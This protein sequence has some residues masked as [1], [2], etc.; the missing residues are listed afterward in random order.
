MTAADVVRAIRAR[1]LLFT[2]CCIVPIAAAAFAAAH[3]PAPVY[4][5]TAGLIVVPTTLADGVDAYQNAYSAAAAC[6]AADPIVCIAGRQPRCLASGDRRL[7]PGDNP[8]PAL[9][10]S[11]CH[12]AAKQRRHRHYGERRLC[13]RG[14]RYR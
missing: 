5:A 6:P 9:P 1:W 4:S 10:A 8:V 13:C 3:A 7:A 14:A 12:L 11:L 2:V